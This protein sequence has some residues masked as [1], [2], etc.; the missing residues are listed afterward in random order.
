MS[1]ELDQPQPA[2]FIFSNG[3]CAVRLAE[4]NYG[5]KLCFAAKPH[6]SYEVAHG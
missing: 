3:G 1:S 6:I 4:W 2:A 5:R